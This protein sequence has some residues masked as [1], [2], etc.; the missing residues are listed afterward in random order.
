MYLYICVYIYKYIYKYIYLFMFVFVYIL[1]VSIV[2]IRFYLMSWSFD[3][4]ES[5]YFLLVL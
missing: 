4:K 3:D 1:G 2:E 5:L